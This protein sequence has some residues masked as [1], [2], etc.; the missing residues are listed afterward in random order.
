MVHM[1]ST[2]ICNVMSSAVE[3]KIAALYLNE[4]DVIIIWDMLEE[5]VHPQTETSLQNDNHT[6]EGIVNRTITQKLTK[7]TNTRFYWLRE[8]DNQK[9]F[10][11]YWAPGLQ[12]LGDYHTKPH[13]SMHH[14]SIRNIYIQIKI[15]KIQERGIQ[16][17]FV[18]PSGPRTAPAAVLLFGALKS[19]VFQTR[20]LRGNKCGDVFKFLLCITTWTQ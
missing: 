16:E 9:H 11:V 20:S 18:D 14:H 8:Q 12:N 4:K 15:R 3:A 10:Q 13:Q 19:T 2:I 5:T 1:V 17:E 6:A 7:A